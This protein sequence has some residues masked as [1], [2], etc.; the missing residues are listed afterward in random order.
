MFWRGWPGPVHCDLVR[1]LEMTPSN[2]T[3][4]RNRGQSMTAVSNSVEMPAA[5]R[6]QET[7]D[8]PTITANSTA[9]AAQSFCNIPP[10]APQEIGNYYHCLTQVATFQYSYIAH[11]LSNLF[12]QFM[13]VDS[14]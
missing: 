10:T 4:I 13:P 8:N 14:Q 11:Q 12:R 9:A 3:T 1:K 2:Y 5:S 7:S 6:L